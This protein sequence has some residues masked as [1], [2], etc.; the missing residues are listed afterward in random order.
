MV[1][2]S[3][4]RQTL[5]LTLA[6]GAI[7]PIFLARSRESFT[8][9]PL[10]AV[11]TSPVL[12]PA[13]A[14]GPSDCASSTMAPSALL[15]AEAVGNARGHGLDLHADPAALDVALVLELRDHGLHGV[16]R[17]AE[18]DADRAAGRRVDRGVHRDHLAVDVE[19][20]AAGVALVD[21]RV[22]LDE[23]VV[24]TRADVAAARRDDAGGRRCRRGRTDC[25]PRPPSRRPA[26]GLSAN[27]TNG[28][29]CS[30]STLIS[31][32]SVFWSV[33]TTFAV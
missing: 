21:R 29:S 8:A 11:M 7:A 26:A 18:A 31:A 15:Q 24:G 10:T 33:P 14:A 32:R 23:V 2:C 20:R 28:K 22:D 1:F 19:G 27:V 17:D 30:A 12:T 16:G 13:L 3:P 5:S 25:R 9:S 6:P 4:L